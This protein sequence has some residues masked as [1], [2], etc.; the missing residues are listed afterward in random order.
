MTDKDIEELAKFAAE[1]LNGGY[2]DDINYYKYEHKKAWENM[3]RKL[4]EK[5]KML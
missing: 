5:A 3:V 4:L 2:Y 1:T